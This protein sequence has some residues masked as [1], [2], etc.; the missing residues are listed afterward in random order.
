[1]AY[2]PIIFLLNIAVSHSSH[3]FL[4]SLSHYHHPNL[5]LNWYLK[6]ALNLNPSLNLSVYYSHKD[7]TCK[8]DYVTPL[9]KPFP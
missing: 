5:F 3:L 7:L 2:I 4:P 8:S 6:L 9:L 1:M